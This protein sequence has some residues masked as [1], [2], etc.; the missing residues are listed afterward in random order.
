M[1]LSVQDYWHSAAICLCKVSGTSSSA[2]LCLLQLQFCALE[3]GECR[4]FFEV[5]CLAEPVLGGEGKGPSQRHCNSVGGQE[6]K[7]ASQ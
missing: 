1:C 3:R 2:Q 5:Y 4:S 7:G 6:G